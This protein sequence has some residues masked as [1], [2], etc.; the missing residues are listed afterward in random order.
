[1]ESDSEGQQRIH[2][3]ALERGAGGRQQH[4]SRRA[5]GSGGALPRVLASPL[6]LRQRCRELLQAEIGQTVAQPE[7][8]NEELRHLVAVFGA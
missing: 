4:G 7:D 3:H 8:I 1:M 6:R 2:D 5:S